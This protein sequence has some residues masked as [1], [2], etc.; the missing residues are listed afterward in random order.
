MCEIQSLVVRPL[1]T[2]II[3]C[4]LATL[5]VLGNY[6]L[7][8]SHRCRDQYTFLDL[9]ARIAKSGNFSGTPRRPFLPSSRQPLCSPPLI[10]LV[11]IQQRCISLTG[12]DEI[13]LFFITSQTLCLLVTFDPFYVGE[14]SLNGVIFVLSRHSATSAMAGKSR[15][16]KCSLISPSPHA[17]VVSFLSAKL[18]WA[19]PTK[20][21]LGCRFSTLIGPYP[22]FVV[23]SCAS[24]ASP[25]LGCI[26]GT[27][28]GIFSAFF[29][30]EMFNIPP[31][32]LGKERSFP[33]SFF[34]RKRIS[35]PYPLFCIGVISSGSFPGNLTNLS[36]VLS[37]CVSSCT[38]PEEAARFI[39]TNPG[40]E[41]C[42]STSQC[43]VTKFRHS[44]SAMKVILTHPNFV[45]DP[46]SSYLE[47]SYASSSIFLLLFVLVNE[48][49]T[50]P[51][52]VT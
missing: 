4:A 38:E 22:S 35:P 8:S 21:H 41:D 37:P 15:S 50:F 6:Y 17:A 52:F 1:N 16:G 34:H 11:S 40:G 46:L 36:T 33:S 48:D 51:P 39:S 14:V 45:P 13:R 44:G 9:C 18:I 31:S 12:L 24:V 25:P 32:S 49:V 23:V 26:R 3:C 27:F 10:P 5:V 7:Y 47:D 30:C 20:P 43:K 42:V 19:W 28:A 2:T 29:V